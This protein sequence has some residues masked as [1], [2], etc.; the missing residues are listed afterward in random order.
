VNKNNI[1]TKSG[2]RKKD[3]PKDS[4]PGKFTLPENKGGGGS[5]ELGRGRVSLGRVKHQLFPNIFLL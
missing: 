5:P 4:L 3:T 1:I 2:W